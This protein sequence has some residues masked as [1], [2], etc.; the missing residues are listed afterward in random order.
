TIRYACLLHDIGHAPFSH[1]L[2][3]LFNEIECKDL[4][5]AYGFSF[6]VDEETSAPH[7]RM[8]CLIALK[9]FEEKFKELKIDIELFCRMILGIE[10]E[11]GTPKSELNPLINL[12]N[13]YIDV[14]KLDYLMRDNIMTGVHMVSLDKERII[15]SYTVHNNIL[16]LSSKALSVVSNLIYGRNAMYLWVYN[17]H[18]VSYYTSLIQRYTQYLIEVDPNV[19]KN[20]IFLRYSNTTSFFESFVKMY[21]TS[22]NALEV[23]LGSNKSVNLLVSFSIKT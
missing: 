23:V 20:Y 1:A 17:H 7:E 15:K 21:G 14:D 18:I 2:E 9:F 4:L 16:V 19:K 13:S 10:Y 22:L 8:S 12:L 3:H 11:I 6:D 5:K